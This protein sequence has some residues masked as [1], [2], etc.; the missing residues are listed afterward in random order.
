MRNYLS[1]AAVIAGGCLLSSAALAD[2]V[3]V[4][5]AVNFG[6]GIV[7]DVALVAVPV[8][9]AWIG[10]HVSNS[11]VRAALNDAIERA[12]KGVYGA[13]ATQGSDV[14]NVT[15]TNSAI[16]SAVSDVVRLMPAA[17]ATFG[18]QPDDVHAAIR[19]E[20][21]GLLA[22]DSTV[23]VMPEGTGIVAKPSMAEQLAP[24]VPPKRSPSLDVAQV[25]QGAP[26]GPGGL[27]GAV[28]LGLG[29]GA[30]V[31]PAAAPIE[32][33]ALTIIDSFGKK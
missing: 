27:A 21:G 8:L 18:W 17:L 14:R 12:A 31:A 22:A 5:G 10:K 16:A 26:G 24:G 29:V 7:Q 1:T 28:Q 13:I 19:K 6:L 23:T 4:S 15:I 20:L 32:A 3:D 33:A 2:T 25:L 9:L 11:F 30:M